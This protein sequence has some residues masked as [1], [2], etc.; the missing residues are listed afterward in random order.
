MLPMPSKDFARE[1]PRFKLNGPSS[2]KDLSLYLH[3]L[4]AVAAAVLVQHA[5]HQT[6][7]L[8]MLLASEKR[9]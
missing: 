1:T 2:K 8:C 4:I 9:I 3:A 6:R 5:S 7:N